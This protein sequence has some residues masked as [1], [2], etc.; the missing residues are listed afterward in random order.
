MAKDKLGLAFP[1]LPSQEQEQ[2]C[3]LLAWKNVCMCVI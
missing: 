3:P 2:S 1:D